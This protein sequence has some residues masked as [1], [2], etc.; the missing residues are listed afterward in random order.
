MQSQFAPQRAASLDVP[1]PSLQGSSSGSGG[2]TGAPDHDDEDSRPSFFTGL[3]LARRAPEA[4][5]QDASGK[6]KAKPKAKPKP[7]PSASQQKR[8]RRPAAIED[9]VPDPA[10]D[11]GTDPKKG[12]GQGRPR[13]DRRA[14]VLEAL[15]EYK[16]SSM[17]EK[18]FNRQNNNFRRRLERIGCDFV[19][20]LM[21]ADEAA[22]LP[23]TACLS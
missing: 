7:T 14:E 20:E 19:Q 11:T 6:A 16:A 2:A 10:P 18:Y 5:V 1:T 23:E 21:P 8:Q 4:A 17:D 9:G 3:V 15:I 12:R 13:Q 22:K